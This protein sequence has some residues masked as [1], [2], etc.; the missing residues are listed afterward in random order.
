MLAVIE[1]SHNDFHALADYLI[2]GRERPTHP[3]RVAWVLAHNLSTDDA[4][5]AAKIMDVT[6]R[7]S[8]RC[9]N[10]CYHA[11]IN[12]HPDEQPSPEIMQEIARRTLD[13][14]GLGEHQALVMGHGD[15]PHA[16]CHLMINRVHPLTRRAWSTS[17]D[18]RRFDR[19]MKQ[20]SEEFGF[21][22]VPGHAFEPELTDGL[23]KAPGSNATHAA[24]RGANTHRTQWSRA[25]SRE[26]GAAA[27]EHLGRHHSFDG[28][29]DWIASQGLQLEAKGQGF[30]IG[31]AGSYTKLSALGLASSARDGLL[32]ALGKTPEPSTRRRPPPRAKAQAWAARRL[33]AVDAIDIARALGT[34]A[35]V[36]NAVQDAVRA[37]RARLARR[38][39]IDQL[40]EEL[41]EQLK[42]STA[43]SRP[44]VRSSVH[45]SRARRSPPDRGR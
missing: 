12:W 27:A 22:Y 6:A 29:E 34:K 18:Y 4:M 38:P 40:M 28:L 39:V 7:L 14:A 10:A 24:R 25:A 2:H 37:R 23:P 19:I 11:S 1:P 13:M 16:H 3:N 33:F 35:D 44:P 41:K 20:L 31:D 42:A 5:R 26:L 36:R 9:T 17:H 15:K 45:R 32:R 8:R 30:V 21:R 43:L